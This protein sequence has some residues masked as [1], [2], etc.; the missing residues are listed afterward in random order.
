MLKCDF[1]YVLWDI[2]ESMYMEEVGYIYWWYWLFLSVYYV[3]GCNE[4]DYIDRKICI[5]L[6]KFRL[7]KFGKLYFICILY[8]SIGFFLF[9]Y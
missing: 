8:L 5:D 9:L 1:I 4:C 6:E 7:F 3:S 2:L